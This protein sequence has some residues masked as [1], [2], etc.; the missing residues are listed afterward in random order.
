[1][2]RIIRK[3]KIYPRLIVSFIV[4][5]IT[6]SAIISG[7]NARNYVNKVKFSY[8]KKMEYTI[9]I[10]TAL[11]QSIL[12]RY[13]ELGYR[14]FDD[15]RVMGILNLAERKAQLID[16]SDYGLLYE[17]QYQ[18]Y[19]HNLGNQLYEIYKK[20]NYIKSIFF[21]VEDRQY[22]MYDITFERQG[23][24]ISDVEGFIRSEGFK[25]ILDSQKSPV[26]SELNYTYFDFYGDYGKQ[27]P[28]LM[29]AINNY[30]FND[31]FNGTLI[32]CIN[33]AAITDVFSSYRYDGDGNVL[34]VTET[35]KHISLQESKENTTTPADYEFPGL[36]GPDDRSIKEEKINGIKSIVAYAR[37]PG[38]GMYT[39][40]IADYS[41]L[42]KGFET[43]KSSNYLMILV[44]IVL[45]MII[46]YFITLSITR[47]LNN[48]KKTMDMTTDDNFDNLYLDS[49]GEMK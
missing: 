49:T 30:D 45:S 38:T 46:H 22:E 26:W 25:Q 19:K 39:I 36:I 6:A 17:R 29:L 11:I 43:I 40:N 4:I 44:V 37:I 7:F 32:I 31:E 15:N 42:L 20:D 23:G 34:L 8:Y 18:S 27:K 5:M 16:G 3:M 24:H 33:M 13:E 48:L 28:V 21:L 47:P 9:N 41:N 12:K 14:I 2:I 10:S 1:M 35:S